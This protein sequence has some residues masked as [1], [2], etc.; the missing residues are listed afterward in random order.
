MRK[1]INLRRT[2]EKWND[3]ILCHSNRSIAP[4]QSIYEVTPLARNKTDNITAVTP[5]ARNKTDNITAVT[6]LAR[7][8]TDNITAVRPLA[9]R[10]IHS[11]I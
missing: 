11:N 10:P 6:P 2:V 7:N 5:L 1:Y 3:S 9:L 8:K 4:K